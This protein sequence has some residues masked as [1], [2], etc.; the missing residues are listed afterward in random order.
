MDERVLRS[1]AKWPDVPDVYGWLSLDRRGNW[2]LKGERIGNQALRDF[3]S[4]TARSASSSRSPTRRWWSITRENHSQTTA[5][6]LLRRNGPSSTTRA[7]YCCSASPVLRC[8]MTGI[9]SATRTGR[10]AC[11]RSRGWRWQSAS[12]SL[13]IQPHESLRPA[14]NLF[15]I[16][17]LFCT[18][19]ATR[20][21]PTWPPGSFLDLPKHGK[22]CL[23]SIS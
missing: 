5:A 22:R 12:D 1:M 10:P 23:P 16:R 3:I 15:I 17:P 2:L 8:W 20:A 4:R 11:G 19:A 14:K 7:R 6:G 18:W 9:L 13:R 21:L